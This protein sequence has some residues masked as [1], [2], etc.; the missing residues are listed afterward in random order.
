MPTIECNC[1]YDGCPCQACDCWDYT[2]NCMMYLD[3]SRCGASRLCK[4]RVP[5][6]LC[7]GCILRDYMMVE[8]LCWQDFKAPEK[9]N[10]SLI[11]IWHAA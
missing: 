8:K 10:I 1:G 2:C 4:G 5:T 6:H 7:V 11:R 9:T 3:C